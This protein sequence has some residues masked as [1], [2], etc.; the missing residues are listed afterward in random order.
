MYTFTNI[1]ANNNKNAGEPTTTTKEVNMRWIVCLL[2]A[3]LT[4]QSI[5]SADVVTFKNGDRLTG[6]IKQLVD[7]NMVFA[8]EQLGDVNIDISKIETFTTDEPI[9]I[10]LADGTVI[11][12]K[13]DGTAP[14]RLTIEKTATITQQNIAIEKI[15]AINPPPE[16]LPKW[17]GDITAGFSSSHGNTSTQNGTL[18]GTLKRRSEKDRIKLHT[19]YTL[20]RTRSPNESKRTTIEES[21]T[22]GGKYDYFFT[23]KF[24]GYTSGSFKKDHIADLDYRLIGGAG[25]GYQWV[26]SEKIS[27]STDAGMAELCEQYTT[28]NESTGQKETEKTDQLSMQFGYNLDW[29]INNK[30]TFSHNVNY[31]PST[32]GPSSYFLNA[33]AEMRAAFT[34]KMFGSLKVV[35]DYDSTTADDVKTTDMKY[36]AGVGWTF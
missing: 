15:A 5:G 20:G 24:Y 1:R 8:S 23:E 31:Y 18:S 4:I 7:G 2:I 14:G 32:K 11:K 19:L 17:N 30:L 28:K 25:V 6:K 10:H 9:E 21:L 3:I 33:E 27:F 29:I 34:E 22:L 26:E 13:T 12:S 16:P 35:M 36:I